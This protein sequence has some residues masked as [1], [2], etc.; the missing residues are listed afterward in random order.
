MDGGGYIPEK[1]KRFLFPPHSV[2]IGYGALSAI[3]PLSSRGSFLGNK[4]IGA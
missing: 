3:Y 2:Q 1:D 4:A